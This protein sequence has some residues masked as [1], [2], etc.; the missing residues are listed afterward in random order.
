MNV[1]YWLPPFWILQHYSAN[2]YYQVLLEDKGIREDFKDNLILNC[3]IMFFCHLYYMLVS[4]KLACWQ[5]ELKIKHLNCKN[6]SLPAW[7]AWNVQLF[8]SS[9]LWK[10]EVRESI[11]AQ[12]FC[13][14]FL[15]MFSQHLLMQE[16][17]CIIFY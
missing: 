5:W 6:W 16:E 4:L 10:W 13:G 2:I 9:S 15:Y 3:L 12:I 7:N 14:F 8:W 17:F 11:I 1:P